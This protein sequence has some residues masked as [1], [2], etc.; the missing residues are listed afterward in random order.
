L[1][2]WATLV[3]PVVVAAALHAAYN[4]ARFGS[5]GDAGYHYML[6]GQDFQDLVARYGRFSLHFLKDN[7][8]GWLFRG[9]YFDGSVWKP[10][11]HGMSLLLTTPYLL[12]L[13]WPRRWTRLEGLA[14]ASFVLCVT[15]SLLYYNDGWVHFGQRFAL[16]GIV[17]ALVAASYG[18]ARAPVALVVFLTAW[19]VA[20]G[21]WGLRWFQASFLH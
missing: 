19:G 14:L 8:M 21:A 12:L 7:L 4:F 5:P 10:D 13:L 1:R 3:A 20:V 2:D 11:P 15:P 6:M 17:L 18:A 16:D 9:P